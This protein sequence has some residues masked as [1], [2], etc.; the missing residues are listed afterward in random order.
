[1]KKC[2]ICDNQLTGNQIKF[3]SGACKQ[4]HAYYITKSNPNTMWHQTK[5]GIERKI[6]F[7]NEFGG[8]C[9][10]C[11]YCKNIGALE[12]HHYKDNKSYNLDM[13]KLSNTSIDKLREELSKCI[14]LCANC[15]REHHYPDYN[16]LLLL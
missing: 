11:G 3:C 16:N 14:L 4:K 10:Q 15:H 5:R 2:V 1:M 6:L 8:K 9:S 12:F 7:I 13:R